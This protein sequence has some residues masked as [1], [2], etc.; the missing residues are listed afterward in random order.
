MGMELNKVIITSEEFLKKL[1]N[2]EYFKSTWNCH[3]IENICIEGKLSIND[4]TT[5]KQHISFSECEV[6]SDVQLNIQNCTEIRI[7]K[8]QFKSKSSFQV[9][10]IK[11]LII[12][13]SIF[14]G[15]VD[16]INNEVSTL[17][18]SNSIFN[19]NVRFTL[20][21]LLSYTI[22]NISVY[23]ENTKFLNQLLFTENQILGSI[24]FRNH[25]N[26]SFIKSLIINDSTNFLFGIDPDPIEIEEINIVGSIDSP[27]YFQFKNLLVNKI[28]FSNIFNY[29][30][31]VFNDIENLK[32]EPKIIIQNSDLG[33]TTFLNCNF[34]DFDLLYSSSKINSTTIVGGYFPGPEK[35]KKLN[36]E[37]NNQDLIQGL[38][39]FKKLYESNGDFISSTKFHEYELKIFHLLESDN[40][41][42]SQLKKMYEQ[43][44]DS[45]N[46]L[47]F[48]AM[49]LETHMKSSDISWSE[50]LN[51][52]FS[53]WSNNFGTDWVKAA[54]FLL[55]WSIPFYLIFIFIQG[56]RPGTDLNLFLD[57]VANYFEYLN[58][59]RRS[60]FF[61]TNN[62]SEKINNSARIVDFFARIFIAFAEY[63][64]IQAFRKYGKK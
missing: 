22:L 4:L 20:N 53:F 14:E 46:A 61:V 5:E 15:K 57:I 18:I 32:K 13:D 44:G 56:H 6:K 26:E 17:L 21:K 16:F 24:G 11:D 62:Q 36:E 41:V 31:I 45:V 55:K 35:F 59:L 23:V 9:R 52:Q 28:N 58:P 12:S 39:Q 38:S 27:N 60:D 1:Y 48:Q 3:I 40:L 43:R 51:L 30:K 42:I 19:E 63:Q 7:W 33:N 10:T 8:C 64:L 34:K 54:K 50:R 2:N 29:G 49:E 25:E 37:D 47:K